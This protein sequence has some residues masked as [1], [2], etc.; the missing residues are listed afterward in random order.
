MSPFPLLSGGLI[1]ISVGTKMLLPTLLMLL[2]QF[3]LFGEGT[4]TTD[5]YK[6][7]V[8]HLCFYDCSN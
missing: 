5:D 3:L 8:Y 6:E 1:G 2:P 7:A 4:F